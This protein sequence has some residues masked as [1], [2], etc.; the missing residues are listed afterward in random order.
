MVQI[1]VPSRDDVREYRQL[2]TAVEQITGRINGR[3][4]APGRDV[5]VHCLYRGLTPQRL[6]ACYAAADVML[7]T[8]LVDGMNLAAR[9]GRRR[10]VCP[11]CA[12]TR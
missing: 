3:F 2:R 7:V 12:L 8:P 5:P 4:T 9:T 1:A 11:Q 6:T 10:S